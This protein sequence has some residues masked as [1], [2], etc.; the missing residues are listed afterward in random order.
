[1]CVINLMIRPHLRTVNC[2]GKMSFRQI[3]PVA[4]DTDHQQQ[5]V[6]C[7]HHIRESWNHFPA[8]KQRGTVLAILF[9]RAI[10]FVGWWV[11][12]PVIFHGNLFFKHDS[13]LCTVKLR[14]V[15]NALA[16]F[17]FLQTYGQ[18][19]KCNFFRVICWLYVQ[20]PFIVCA[21]HLI[22]EFC[23]Q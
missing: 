5:C 21:G 4:Y 13:Q 8:C 15:C 23:M 7:D 14:T 9:H 11:S 12:A 22:K 1:M 16:F 6:V 17:A 10:F 20:L 3:Y 18:R 2:Q 19:C